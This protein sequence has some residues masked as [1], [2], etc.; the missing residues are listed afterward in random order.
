MEFAGP[1]SGLRSS[2]A[3]RPGQLPHASACGTGPAKPALAPV[4]DGFLLSCRRDQLPDL[5]AAV[6][7]ACKNATQHCLG[8]FPLK[9]D[10]TV[11]DGRFVDEDGQ[12]M[13]NYLQTLL[14]RSN[15]AVPVA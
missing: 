13:W 11:F 2:E 6:D 5:Q 1:A 10:F 7:F 12:E 3:E 9:W 8:D 15:H 4:H 14:T